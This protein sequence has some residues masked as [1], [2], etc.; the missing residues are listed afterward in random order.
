MIN[1]P[2]AGREWWKTV[3]AAIKGWGPTIR[4]VILVAAPPACWII[5]LQIITLTS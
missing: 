4:L 5:V 3:R 1:G 2:G